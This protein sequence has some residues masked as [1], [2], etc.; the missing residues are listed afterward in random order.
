MPRSAVRGNRGLGLRP[1]FTNKLGIRHLLESNL[2]T[3]KD[4]AVGGRDLWHNGAYWVVCTNLL[5]CRKR[6]RHTCI[7][8]HVPWHKRCAIACQADARRSDRD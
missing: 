3:V 6:R 1:T 7:A 2:I 4:Y 8:L 5:L